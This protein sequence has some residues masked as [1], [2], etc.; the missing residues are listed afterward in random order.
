[1]MR[2][3]DDTFNPHLILDSYSEEPLTLQQVYFWTVL[4]RALKNPL[5]VT[6]LQEYLPPND[7][8]TPDAINCYFK[9]QDLQNHSLAQPYILHYSDLLLPGY[10]FGSS[11]VHK[12]NFS[13]TGL[14]N[15]SC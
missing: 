5:G 2:Q 6:A 13:H 10:I 7:H 11:V 12:S 9:H 1:M 4:T 14:A 8:D 3:I 15:Y